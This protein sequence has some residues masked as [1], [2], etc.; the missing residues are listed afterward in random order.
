M[1]NENKKEKKTRKPSPN[2]ITC[3]ITGVSRMSNKVY[4]ANKAEKNGTTSNVWASF[5]VSKPAYKELVEY[6]SEF[7]FQSA[8]AHYGVEGDRL[9][10][11]LRF[12]GRGSFVKIAAAHEKEIEENVKLE[13]AA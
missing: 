12:N 10:K 6:V 3:Q 8:A 13:K 5:Y 1:K 4:I 2:R 7:G 11:W 9:K